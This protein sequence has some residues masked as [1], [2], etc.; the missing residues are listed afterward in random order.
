LKSKETFGIFLVYVEVS[1]TEKI[2]LSLL[3]NTADDRAFSIKVSQLT[4]FDNVAPTGC[5]QYFT[6]T[7]GQIKSFNYDDGYSQVLKY[8]NPSYFVSFYHIYLIAHCIN[9]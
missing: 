3:T 1:G 2:F 7:N 5:L 6:E 8:R 4:A 9:Y